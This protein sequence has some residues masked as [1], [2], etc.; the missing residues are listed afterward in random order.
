[1][2]SY[3]LS[4]VILLEYVS[5]VAQIPNTWNQIN[6]FPGL[7]RNNVL[8]ASIGTKALVGSG[9]KSSTTLKDFW[10]YDGTNDTWTSIADLPG[11]SREHAVCFT[12][13]NDFYVGLGHQY[14]LSTSSYSYPTDFYKY[15]LYS[16][17]WTSVTGFPGQGREG[18]KSFSLNGKGYVVG[19]LIPSSTSFEIEVWEFNPAN[20][21]WIQRNNGPENSGSAIEAGLSFSI[22]QK[23]YLYI[24]GIDWLPTQTDTLLEYNPL[25]DTWAYKA[26]LPDTARVGGFGFVL[27]NKA[28]L[29]GGTKPLNTSLNSFWE[30]DPA[31]DLWTKRADF[32]PGPR[33]YPFSFA[34]NG[35]G[36]VGSGEAGDRCCFLTDTW[37]YNSTIP[38]SCFDCVWPGDAD[39]NSVVNSSDLLPIAVSYG[40]TGPMRA[41]ASQQWMGQPATNWNSFFNGSINHKHADTNGDG[42]LNG[43]DL[44]ALNSNSEFVQSL[45]F[46]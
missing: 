46:S 6:D 42:I 17:Q 27:N 22:R 44:T 31:T 20:N 3:F 43:N 37:A 34:V 13:G 16:N 9:L 25:T 45:P 15:S 26:S 14:E 2:K 29:G 8:S 1:M 19:G 23:G 32:P 33:L 39:N 38:A 12:I 4:I 40:A 5:A 30:Y 41:N 36:I 10:L 7:V 28:Y 24:P 35:K 11:V 18:A 21:Q